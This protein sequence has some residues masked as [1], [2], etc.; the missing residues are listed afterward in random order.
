[1]A[2]LYTVR[3][4][5]N[6]LTA[7]VLGVGH[8]GLLHGLWGQDSVLLLGGDGRGR[9]HD[10]ENKSRLIWKDRESSG[11]VK[12][13]NKNRNVHRFQFYSTCIF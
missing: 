1:M 8:E 6:E 5:L 7:L 3:Y 11:K 4:V 12:N 9:G 10:L 2:V 13:T